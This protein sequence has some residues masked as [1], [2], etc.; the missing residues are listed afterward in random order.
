MEG[1]LLSCGLLYQGGVGC[2][3]E[4]HCNYLLELISTLLVNNLTH[5]QSEREK[6]RI[7]PQISG[8]GKCLAGS[9]NQ[10]FYF[11]PTGSGSVTTTL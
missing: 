10:L 3:R 7:S 4:T 1:L 8:T 11:N 6:E 2:E 9:E 5:I